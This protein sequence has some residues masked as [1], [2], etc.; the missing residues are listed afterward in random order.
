L[1]SKRLKRLEKFI[2]RLPE[3][4]RK[5]AIILVDGKLFSWNEILE[6]LKK[7]GVLS[8]KIEKKLLEK[9]NG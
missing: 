6:V 2:I 7:D 1:E 5:R 8:K 9:L 3:P 4:E